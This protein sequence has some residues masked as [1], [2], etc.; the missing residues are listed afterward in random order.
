M[1]GAAGMEKVKAVEETVLCSLSHFYKTLKSQLVGRETR[2]HSYKYLPG[3]RG[4]AVSSPLAVGS[5]T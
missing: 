5:L 3:L 2:K 1:L 4:A